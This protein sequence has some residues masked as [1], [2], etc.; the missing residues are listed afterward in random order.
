MPRALCRWC[1][2]QE[3]RCAGVTINCAA[4]IP[5]L[6]ACSMVKCH[7]HTAHRVTRMVSQ[8]P[9]MAQVWLSQLCVGSHCAALC[10][11]VSRPASSSISA[12]GLAPL[13]SSCQAMPGKAPA[14]SP[15]HLWQQLP[16]AVLG[17]GEG[18]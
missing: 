1:Q 9:C 4:S 12:G 2:H 18:T 8:G 16:T 3:H 7:P 17:Q 13:Q 5:L 15:L 14:P 6:S 11:T 10:H